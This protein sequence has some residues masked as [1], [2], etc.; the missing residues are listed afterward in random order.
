MTT[1]LIGEFSVDP[2]FAEC[3][4]RWRPNTESSMTHAGKHA[5][6]AQ[7]IGV[8][9]ETARRWSKFGLTEEEADHAANAIDLHAASVW[10]E[11]WWRSA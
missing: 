3:L 6:I 8:S 5:I 11:D 10:H 4:K 2:L 7:V 1:K 9:R